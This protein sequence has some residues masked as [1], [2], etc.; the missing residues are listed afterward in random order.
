VAKNWTHVR[1]TPDTLKALERVRA[2]MRVAEELGLVELPADDRDRVG[3]DAI[4]ARLIE[5]YDRHAER[6]RRSAAKRR[7]KSSDT[8]MSADTGE[9]VGGVPPTPPDR[10]SSPFPPVQ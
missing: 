9:D 10:S 8:A 1:I 6:R 7:R 2:S 3:L 5:Q 4:I